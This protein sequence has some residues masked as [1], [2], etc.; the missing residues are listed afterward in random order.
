M[1]NY[2]RQSTERFPYIP[3]DKIFTFSILGCHI[4][5]F[6]FGALQMCMITWK[7]KENQSQSPPHTCDMIGMLDN[8]KL[9]VQIQ[10]ASKLTLWKYLKYFKAGEC[11][12]IKYETGF[13][14]SL[15]LFL[16]CLKF[17]SRYMKP[18]SGPWKKKAHQ[19]QTINW[20]TAELRRVK[21]TF[22]VY[23]RAIVSI[24]F[25]IVNK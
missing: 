24:P 1:T 20:E 15:S 14:I 2:I 21:C 6:F 10:V 8:D 5:R 18:E 16:G 22:V 19:K 12:L 3:F 17:F 23:G 25:P 9:Y 7:W 11:A 13:P 4:A